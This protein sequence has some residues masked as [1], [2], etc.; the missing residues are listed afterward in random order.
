MQ[1]DRQTDEGRT[2]NASPFTTIGTVENTTAGSLNSY[3][4]TGA[5]MQSSSLTGESLYDS[6]P[7]R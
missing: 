4:D 7:P 2:D 1:E 6:L 3:S 5:G